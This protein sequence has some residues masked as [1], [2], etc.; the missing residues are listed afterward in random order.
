LITSAQ[1][2]GQDYLGFF[3]PPGEERGFKFMLSDIKLTLSGQ[4]ESM[5]LLND[6][7][8][9]GGGELS[10]GDFYINMDLKVEYLFS[11][12]GSIGA[13]FD[14]VPEQS[15]L[16]VA[17]PAKTGNS[18]NNNWVKADAYVSR[19]Y[20][21]PGLEGKWSANDRNRFQV[22]FGGL[23]AS[24]L[25]PLD[26]IPNQYY[27][28]TPLPLLQSQHYDKGIKINYWWG[29]K[30]NPIVNLNAAL[31]DGDYAIGES[32]VFALHNSANN[33]YPSYAFGWEL[34]PLALTPKVQKYT[35]DLYTGV[36][37]TVGDLGSYPG[38]KRRQNNI[39]T[40]VGYKRKLGPGI[41][42][43]RGFLTDMERN[44]AGD[45]SGNHVD[46]IRT[47]GV[48]GE[49]AYRDCH[50]FNQS[51]D[52]YVS[53]WRMYNRD[54]KADGEIWL[55]DEMGS[56]KGWSFGVKWNDP[57]NITKHRISYLGVQYTR[58]TVDD[59]PF[60]ILYDDND[61]I[62]INAGLRW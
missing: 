5:I 60:N 31:I 49:L 41:I 42:E 7:K 4:A 25:L 44:P 1:L 35:G 11:S 29:A 48:G 57:F 62:T 22:Q 18:N 26:T 8:E 40:Y 3:S 21:L 55:T 9:S 37:S 16:N 6:L 46:P 10:V 39:V 54:D 59:P 61:I 20:L 19:P 32:D 36:T 43:L 58:V 45:G 51:F 2:S 52:Y 47:R 28:N 17:D 13:Y 12:S 27:L 53:L 24:G 50:M 23:L 56:L 38:E 14:W 34:H 33:S 15:V 30:D